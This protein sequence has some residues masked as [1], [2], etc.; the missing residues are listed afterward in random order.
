[1]FP[2]SDKKFFLKVVDAQ[3]AF[4]VDSQGKPAQLTLYQ[5]GLEQTAKRLVGAEAKR[6]MDEADAATKRF[7]EQK[8][9][10]GSEA[11]LRRGIGELQLGQPNYELMTPAL[12]DITRRQLPQLKAMISQLGV[13]ESVTFKGVGPAGA[14]IYEVKFEHGSTE[15]R[16]MLD[17]DGK[18]AGINFRPL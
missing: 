11:A 9:A 1:M 15:W 18:V 6:Q 2:E 8:P 4:D 5:N 16:I 10:P 14:D 13:V 17:S 3:I 12:A 7:K